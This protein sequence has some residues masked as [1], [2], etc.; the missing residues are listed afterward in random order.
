MDALPETKVI[1]DSLASTT[2]P[3]CG[4]WK[5]AKQ[6]VCP[7]EYK[8]LPRDLKE[9]LYDWV[10]EGYEQALLASLNYLGAKEFKRGL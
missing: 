8:K 2:C 6:S 4:G 3:S 7:S 9:R 5:R 1:L 10:G